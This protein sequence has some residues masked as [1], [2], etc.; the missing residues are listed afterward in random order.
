MVRVCD[1]SFELTSSVW[2]GPLRGFIVTLKY[3]DAH[4]CTAFSIYN[5]CFFWCR[6]SRWYLNIWMFFFLHEQGGVKGSQRLLNPYESSRPRTRFQSSFHPINGHGLYEAIKLTFR[7]KNQ[8]LCCPQMV[9]FMRNVWTFLWSYWIDRRGNVGRQP[10]ITFHP[11]GGMK[12]GHGCFSH[13]SSNRK[14]I[15]SR[16]I[17][18]TA[19][20]SLAKCLV[21]HNKTLVVCVFGPFF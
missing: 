15:N 5:V 7:G 4:V 2:T 18:K 11:N 9:C 8:N 16:E 17:I 6:S 3:L 19:S 13:L 10:V 21:V 1:P 14:Y 12:V 20:K